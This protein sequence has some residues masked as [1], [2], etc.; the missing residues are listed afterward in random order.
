MQRHNVP[1]IPWRICASVGF[2]VRSSSA[3][4]V[5]IWPFWQKPHC[6]T[7]S[8]IH[9]CCS[10]CSLPPVASPSSVVISAPATADTG[11]MH[12][13]TASPLMRTVHAPHWPRPQPNRGPCRSRSLRRTYKRGVAGST[14]TVCVFPLTRRVKLAI[15]RR[16]V[17]LPE[18]NHEAHE[19]IED[20]EESSGFSWC[21]S[22]PS[23]PSWSKIRPMNA[24]I[25]VAAVVL[26]M[27][28]SKP[29]A[30][31]SREEWLASV[32]AWRT[33]HEADY[34]RDWATIAGLHFLEPGTHSLGSAK[35][36]EIVLPPDLP[37][38][39]GRIV[40]A[41][42]W[43]RYEPAPGIT[44]TQNGK[45]LSGTV[46]LKEPEKDAADE[47]SVGDVKLAGHQSGDRH[48][49]RVGD[50]VGEGARG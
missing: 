38:T 5:G 12:E 47:I 39:V 3:L 37:S 29:A 41:D 42:G 33:K 32:N 19:E 25:L 8:S 15:A 20:H 44:P 46:V 48:L 45:P 10:G 24:R 14:S 34:R 43:V 50:T 2:G 13:R 4:A 16:S 18:V 22:I 35:A 30:E 31:P 6:G 21:P 26:L 49:L 23:W 7:C 17:Q 1:D 9:A 28:C 36:N 40:V 27:G 11:R